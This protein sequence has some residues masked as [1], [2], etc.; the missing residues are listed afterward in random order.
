MAGGAVGVVGFQP[1]G[2]YDGFYLL[3]PSKLAATNLDVWMPQQ[4]RAARRRS[5]AS[6]RL[7]EQT[8]LR[9]KGIGQTGQSTLGG[10]PWPVPGVVDG[11][12]LLMLWSITCGALVSCAS[13]G[14]V[15]WRVAAMPP[16]LP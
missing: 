9:V 11:R 13:L 5:G 3:L 4:K 8:P 7:E 1:V 15:V 12:A 16:S 10:G 14:A 2:Q 6:H